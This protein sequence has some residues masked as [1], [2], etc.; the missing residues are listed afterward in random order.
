L[1]QEQLAILADVSYSY[2]SLLE[3]EKRDPAFS[4]LQKIANALGVSL[5]ILAFIASNDEENEKLDIE[6]RE[7]LSYVALMRKGLAN[8]R[9]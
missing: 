5:V 1:S 6:I 3:N 8:E 7:K 2:I 9:I 4:V